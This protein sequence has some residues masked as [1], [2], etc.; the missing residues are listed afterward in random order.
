MN[1]NKKV[2]VFSYCFPNET[3]PQSGIFILN[4]CQ[5]LAKLGLE[6]VILNVVSGKTFQPKIV[7]KKVDGLDILECT[8]LLAGQTHIPR[9]TI[10][11]YYYFYCRLYKKAV[12]I[13]GKPDVMYAHFSFPTGFAVR[14]L[15][16]R[17]RI[18][19]VV[20]EHSSMFNGDKIPDYVKKQMSSLIKDARAFMCVS[21]SLK[22]SICSIA[23][24][25]EEIVKIAHNAI[26]SGFEYTPRKDK[27]DF[28]VF[29]AGNLVPIKQYDLLIR[30][31]EILLR[32]GITIK[33]R[34]A[35]EGKERVKLEQLA[36]L[37]NVRDNIS[38][39]G[40]LPMEDIYKEL[41][42]CDAFALASKSETF[43]VAFREAMFVGRPVISFDNGGIREGWRDDYGLI[44]RNQTPE[45]LA[46]GIEMVIDK[47]DGYDLE[48]ISQSSR[49]CFS[50]GNIYPIILQAL[51]IDNY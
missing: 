43:G 46:H 5:Q 8:V 17:Q 33:L 25:A 42:Y 44:V 48:Y 9:L 28:V 35:G 38:F 31:I 11:I 32:K 14:K 36:D 3:N 1:C 6:I 2:F 49:D 19:F 23:A 50:V 7:K 4:Q 22:K 13:F 15:S 26:D 45:A 20:M 41:E 47:Y 30:A 16:D 10:G 27:K 24:D 37:L 51:F 40:R 18:P 29:S 12:S 34:I 39:L 21:E